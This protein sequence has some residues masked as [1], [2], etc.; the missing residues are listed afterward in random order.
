MKPIKRLSFII[1]ATILTI[2]ILLPS[3]ADEPF[4]YSTL[5]ENEIVNVDGKWYFDIPGLPK[6][7]KLPLE[8]TTLK[9]TVT[10]NRPPSWDEL[11]EAVEERFKDTLNVKLNMIFYP[12]AEVAQKTLLS[13]GSGENNDLI[14]HDGRAVYT[15]SVAAGYLENLDEYIEKYA[16]KLYAGR[17]PSVWE[18]SKV[19]GSYYAIP[20]MTT[21]KMGVHFDIRKDVMDEVGVS[22]INS[23]EE[24][25]DFL[26]AAKK[27]RPDLNPICTGVVDSE[28]YM[29]WTHIW[30][31][32]GITTDFIRSTSMNSG[33]LMLYY[34]NNDPIIHNFFDEPDPLIM[35]KIRQARQLY[36]DGIIDPNVLSLQ[37]MRDQVYTG[38]AV[39][40][41]WPQAYCD[42]TVRLNTK[43]SFGS[44]I[45]TYRPYEK[46]EYLQPGKMC[47]DFKAWNFL[48]LAKVSKN[49][50]RA[51]MFLEA[52]QYKQNYDLMA[53]GVEGK[54][55]NL[56]GEDRWTMIDPNFRR[57]AYVWIM[58]SVH[59]RVDASMSDKDYEFER[60][61]RKAPPSDFVFCPEGYLLYDA[62]TCEAELA[63]YRA[64]EARYLPAIYNGVID[65]DQGLADF[66]AE[67]YDLLKVIQDDYQQQLDAAVAEKAPK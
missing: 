45:Y 52:S 60:W 4:D 19:N 43:K 42:P 35:E 23:A 65:P 50:E 48:S 55:S 10:S 9:I 24:F 34:K 20:L 12:N 36:L 8:E 44:E 41:P 6:D 62:S 53:F 47:S 51:M 13:L 28:L 27:A 2:G 16:P 21:N 54:H 56:I 25:V 5:K 29:S 58:D 40:S 22:E 38:R 31:R 3:L 37:T 46:E 32:G 1:I 57:L 26:Y 33:S 17:A 15:N 66:K 11:I 14:W 63:Q 7:T 18:A 49:K 61:L 64:I 30:F 67:A 59:D 39:S